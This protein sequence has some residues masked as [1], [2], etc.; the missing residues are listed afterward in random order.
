MNTIESTFVQDNL[1]AGEFPVKTDVETIKIGL[2]LVRGTALAKETGT[3]ASVD[4]GLDGPYEV[5][6]GDTIV[7]DV[8]N[9]GN[10]TATANGTA[11]SIT[12]STSY[13]CADQTGLTEKIT[14]DDGDEQTITFGTATTAL[15]IAEDINDQIVGAKASVV[16]G[17]VVVT[18]DRKGTGSKIAIGTGTCALT[19][20]AAV[21]GTGD[22]E[23]I[24]A[25]TAEE[26]KTLLEG[27]IAGITVTVVGNGFKIES[28]SY[29]T[30]S[31]LDIK[32]GNLLAIFDIDVAV[33]VGTGGSNKLVVLDKDG[34]DG[35]QNPHSV[36][37]QDCDATDAATEALVYTRGEFNADDLIFADGTTVD[38]VKDAMQQI[39][40]YVRNT[41]D[42]V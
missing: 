1:I 36:L 4:S 25:M 20:S 13:P 3:K 24:D 33:H 21:D 31:E 12:D 15:L 18:S 38:D 8:D 28:D 35:S 19:W 39:G 6:N 41:S 16:G 22:A 40:L 30:T 10:D 37:A 23:F 29:G 9:V 11:G 17:H 2:D 7:I 27:D 42:A 34:E 32:S 26:V 5:E 14:V